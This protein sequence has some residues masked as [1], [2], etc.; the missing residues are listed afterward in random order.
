MFKR[1]ESAR[2]P[3]G[4]RRRQRP[5]LLDVDVDGPLVAVEAA[6]IEPD[7]VYNGTGGEYAEDKSRARARRAGSR[8]VRAGRVSRVERASSRGTKE[9]KDAGRDW[10]SSSSGP[11]R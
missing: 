7:L 2:L 6:L 4:Q 9:T 10:Y 11:S 1:A 3:R 8:E 5:R